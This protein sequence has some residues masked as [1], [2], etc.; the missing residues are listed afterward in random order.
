MSTVSCVRRAPSYG[1]AVLYARRP[2]HIRESIFLNLVGRNRPDMWPDVADIPAIGTTIQA[3]QPVV[4][5]F[6][7]AAT[8]EACDRA[9]RDVARGLEGP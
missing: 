1:K 8:P 6:A 3:G 4:T 7:E 5:I 2:L 9:L